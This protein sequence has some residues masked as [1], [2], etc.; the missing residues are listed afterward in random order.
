MIKYKKGSVSSTSGCVLDLLTKF[1]LKD[2]KLVM[3][4]GVTDND[5]SLDKCLSDAGVK[6]AI[7]VERE[8][9]GDDNM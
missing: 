5:G 7:D 4:V 1:P 8:Y 9:V 6:G 3:E 2:G